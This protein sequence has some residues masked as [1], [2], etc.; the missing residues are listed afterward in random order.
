[1]TDMITTSSLPN[2]LPVTTVRVPHANQVVIGLFVKVGSRYESHGDNGISHFVEHVIFRGNKDHANSRQLDDAFG[3]LGARIDASTGAD[4]TS[5]VVTTSP[6]HAA[7]AINLLLR[8][9]CRPGF[10]EVAKEKELVLAELDS[11]GDDPVEASRAL[12]FGDHPLSLPI[13]G[14]EKTVCGFGHDDVMRH[15]SRYYRPT[16]MSLCVVGNVTHE[17]ICAAAQFNIIGTSKGGGCALLADCAHAPPVELQGNGRVACID[18]SGDQVDFVLSMRGVAP[19]HRLFAATVVLE[20]IIDAR[21]H[22]HAADQTALAYEVG[23]TMERFWD[24]SVIDICATVD[25]KKLDALTFCIHNT[26]RLP[27]TSQ[28]VRHAQRR[29][30]TEILGHMENLASLCEWYGATLL[31]RSPPDMQSMLAAIRQVTWQDVDA[32]AATMRP[33]YSLVAMGDLTAAARK[34]FLKRMQQQPYFVLP[35][36]LHNNAKRD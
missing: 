16:N 31:Y 8:V 28:E 36:D 29:C 26:L 14:Y 27:V 1:M 25:A 18:T 12:M 6:S 15:H 3:E 5:F 30:E 2:G 21:V 33:Q 23:S 34:A 10:H 32:V 24:L 19:W 9:V 22:Y 17:T 35:R 7:E 13:L 4:D 20:R 11:T